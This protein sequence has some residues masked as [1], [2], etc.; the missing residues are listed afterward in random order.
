MPPMPTPVPMAPPPPPP[1]AA[2]PQNWAM[3]ISARQR[4]LD[5]EPAPARPQTQPPIQAHPQAPA[6]VYAPAPA[7]PLAP[8]AHP[9]GWHAQPQPQPQGPDLSGLEQ[10]L[11]TITSQIASL[12]RPYEDGFAALRSDLAEIG[13]AL[14]DA[15]PRRAVEALEAEVRALSERVDRSRS[16]GPGPGVDP[17]ALSGLEHGLA[18]V[19]D[20]LHSLTPAESL[21][22]VD[23]AVR[24]LS[25]KIDQISMSTQDP[26]IFQQIEHAIS[27][28]RSAV[29]NVA[30]DGALAQLAAEVHHLANHFEQNAAAASNTSADALARLDARISDLLESGRSV[31]PELEASIR[32][33]SDQLERAQLSQGDKLALGS[34]E[35]RIVKLFE[36]LDASE[37]RLSSLGA[38]ERG[39][40]DLLVAVEDIRSGGARGPRAGFAEPPASAPQPIP[41]AAQLNYPPPAIEHAPPRHRL[42]RRPRRRLSSHRLRSR[43]RR[44]PRRS[45]R[46][47][48]RRSRRARP[49]RAGRSIPIFRPTRR[50][51]PAWVRRA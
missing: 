32:A 33:L 2:G 14:T 51:N 50:S 35:D 7:P 47:S 5:G 27:S 17:S 49:S 22:G 26:E 43:A 25:R 48:V 18:E 3:E 29:S 46:R 13:R 44:R 38:I 1:P 4:A 39:M 31:P 41:P 11:R 24:G 12:H 28:L 19:R 9:S 15:M 40:A 34:L 6:P 10:H 36:K 16:A 8:A 23:E 42:L 21:V 30:S 37:A 20:A 45:R